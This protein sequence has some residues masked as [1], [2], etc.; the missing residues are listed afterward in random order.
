MIL[1]LLILALRHAHLRTVRSE[2]SQPDRAILSA[3]QPGEH[4]DSELP[5]HRGAGSW[6]RP[7]MACYRTRIKVRLGVHRDGPSTPS[8]RRLAEVDAA[9]SPKRDRASM[10]VARHHDS[11]AARRGWSRARGPRPCQATV[12]VSAAGVAGPPFRRPRSRGGQRPAGR[13]LGRA[14]NCQWRAS[15][16]LPVLSEPG[17]KATARPPPSFLFPP[18]GGPC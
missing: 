1:A 8:P 6:P 2:S 13:G 5:G 3:R 14:T 12:P 9:P 11:D 16:S 17:S 4:S 18:Q 7:L 15:L 10:P